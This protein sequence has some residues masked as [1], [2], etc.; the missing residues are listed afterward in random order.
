MKEW[1]F[2]K[3]HGYKRKL[4]INHKKKRQRAQGKRLLNENKSKKE[5]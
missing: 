4:E 3:F 5:G 1:R 2:E